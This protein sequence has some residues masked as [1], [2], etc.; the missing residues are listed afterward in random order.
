MLTTLIEIKAILE[1][2]QG[3]RN[4][5]CERLERLERLEPNRILGMEKYDNQNLNL[6][7]SFN[8][9]LDFTK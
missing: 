4:N 8:R 1:D 6:N 5:K 2:V 7:K 9:K 3:T